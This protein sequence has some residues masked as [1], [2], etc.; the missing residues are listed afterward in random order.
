MADP[1]DEE[2]EFLLYRCL[3]CNIG[4]FPSKVGEESMRVGYSYKR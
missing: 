1:E 4:E 2:E 3:E